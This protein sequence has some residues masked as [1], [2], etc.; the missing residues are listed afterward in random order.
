MG[1]AKEDDAATKVYETLLD[2]VSHADGWNGR[3]IVFRA[4]KNAE[5][6]IRAIADVTKKNSNDI[7]TILGEHS[8]LGFQK[9]VQ[10][11]L[12]D[13]SKQ[14]QAVM[15]NITM[16]PMDDAEPPSERRDQGQSR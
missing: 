4:P 12:E 10:Q 7:R 3:A 1:E 9:F 13:D 16:V 15:E 8:A 2:M 6:I 5:S 14:R 11:A